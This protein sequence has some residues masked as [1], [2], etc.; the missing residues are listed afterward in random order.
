MAA[1]R[2]IEFYLRTATSDVGLSSLP[3]AMRRL[4]RAVTFVAA[5]LAGVAGVSARAS[6]SLLLEQPYGGLGMFNPTGHAAVYLDHVCAASPLELRP[7]RPG[8]LGVVISRYD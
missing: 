4:A 5:A 2:W 1:F 3:N 8:E 7:C 6:V